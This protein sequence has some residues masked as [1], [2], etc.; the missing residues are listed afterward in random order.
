MIDFISIWAPTPLPVG[1]LV[2]VSYKAFVP[3]FFFCVL[4]C[5]VT[6]DEYGLLAGFVGLCVNPFTTLGGLLWLCWGLLRLFQGWVTRLLFMYSCS[7]STLHPLLHLPQYT[8]KP[9]ITNEHYRLP[10]CA[11]SYQCR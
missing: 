1:Y 9:E 5:V 3:F 2:S 6:G 8:D 10:S 7:S 4:L 11:S